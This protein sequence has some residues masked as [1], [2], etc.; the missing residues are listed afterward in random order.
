MVVRVLSIGD[1]A[2]FMQVLSKFVKRSEIHVINFPLQGASKHVYSKNVEFFDSR[3]IS[4]C[5]KKINEIK[6]SS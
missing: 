6:E 2:N 5:L 4:D 1:T 3:K